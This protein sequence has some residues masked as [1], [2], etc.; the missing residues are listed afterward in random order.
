MSDPARG[1]ALRVLVTSGGFG[2][3]PIGDIVRSFAGI[4]GV[5]LTVVCGR[6]RGWRR[7][8]RSSRW[9]PA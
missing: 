7:A 5:E 9:R 4:D 2:V 6:A 1:E 3:G 8:S